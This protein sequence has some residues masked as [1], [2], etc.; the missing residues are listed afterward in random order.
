MSVTIQIV[1]WRVEAFILSGS[2]S[3]S[4]LWRLRPHTPLGHGAQR[5]MANLARQHTSLIGWLMAICFAICAR[6]RTNRHTHKHVK[7]FIAHVRWNS[8]VT[9]WPKYFLNLKQ[10][11]EKIL[12]YDVFFSVLKTINGVLVVLLL[13]IISLPLLCVI[14]NENTYICNSWWWRWR[15]VGSR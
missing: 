13:I 8:K 12:R 5:A 2:W 14:W 1:I 15:S 7:H 9:K 4:V 3:Q 6:Y 10:K 11:T